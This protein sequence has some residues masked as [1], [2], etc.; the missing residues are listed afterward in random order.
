MTWNIAPSQDEITQGFGCT[1][2][3]N[4]WAA[5]WCPSGH[6]HAG[7]DLGFAAGG[8]LTC[9]KPVYA[10]RQ[11]VVV[12]VGTAGTTDPGFAQYLGPHAVCVHYPTEGIYLLHGH[13]SA[14]SVSVGQVVQPGDQ[15]GAIGTLGYS[16]ACHLHV[17]ARTDGPFQNVN[18][19]GAALRDPTPYLNYLP[20]PQPSPTQEDEMLIIAAPSGQ[21][22][23]LLSGSLFIQI[24]NPQTQQNLLAAG[25]KKAAVDVDTFNALKAAANK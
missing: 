16:S 12:A 14:A 22:I 23:W 6:L 10:T 9:G 2:Y 4:E 7:I 13:L 11:G 18:N 24:G 15:L 21:G 19:Q 17:E 20:A 8:D 25:V 5:P 3:S 1:D